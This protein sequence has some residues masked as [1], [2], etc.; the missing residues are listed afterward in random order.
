MRSPGGTAGARGVDLT[1][2]QDRRESTGAAVLWQ[3]IVGPMLGVASCEARTAHQAL[4]RAAIAADLTGL[5]IEPTTIEA[6]GEIADELVNAADTFG[7][8][9]AA[10]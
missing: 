3:G 9:R 8:A 4:V 10:P 5:E 7:R 6:V 2:Y 1:G